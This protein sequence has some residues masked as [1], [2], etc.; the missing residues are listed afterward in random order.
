MRINNNVSA[1]IANNSVGRN[2]N[3]A[4]KSM[5]K[6]STGLRINRAADDAAGLAVS[7][8]MRSQLAGL[9][10]ANKNSQDAVS[11]LQ[12]AEGALNEV[13]SITVRMKE[14]SVQKDNGT[15]SAEDVAAIDLEMDAL[16]EEINNIYDNTK[17][18]GINVFTGKAGNGAAQDIEMRIGNDASQTMTIAQATLD[19]VIA[20]DAS[21]DSTAIDEA[22]AQ[23][24][25]QRATYG[26][27]QNRLEHN[28]NNLT[29]THENLT[30]AESRIRDTDLAKEMVEFT[31]NNIL[32]QAAQS[33]L[34]Q[35]NQ[36]PQ[37]VL[38]LL[39]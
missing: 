14:L 18:N 27:Q 2:T 10:Q 32:N 19:K 38:Q 16:G 33:M 1:L 28:M 12:T 39:R 6:L 22:I 20:L 7:E 36:Q 30:S 9:E 3:A 29:T 8:K 15:L 24:N 35:A 23:L 13:S 34:T 26:A 17:F 21:S 31:K 4:A 11:Y 5:E 37:N 25:T